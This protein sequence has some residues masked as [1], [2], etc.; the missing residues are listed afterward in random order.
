MMSRTRQPYAYSV[1]RYVHDVATGECVNVGVVVTALDGSFVAGKFR[2]TFL[3]I[4]QLFPS[5]D[6]EAF[7][8]RMGSIQR[9]FERLDEEAIS[10]V[11]ADR[12]DVAI[13]RYT[14]AVIPVDDSSLQWAASGS[15]VAIDRRE[16][17]ADLYKR[18]VT[19]YDHAGA[20]ERRKDDDVWRKFRSELEKRNVLARLQEK[21][22]AVA[23][24]AVKFEHAWKNGAWHCY[25][26]VSFDLA[27]AAAIR[28]KAHRWLGQIS[29]VQTAP[30]DFKVYFLVGK[31]GDE[32][33]REHYIKA[34]SILKKSDVA[35]IVEEDAAE[36][37]SIAVA[38]AMSRHDSRPLDL[39]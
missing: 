37:F 35:Q 23:D 24:D 32:D 34:L 22:I 39:Q 38:D 21:T 6:G 11:T 19:H 3:R 29:S 10:S 9:A 12:P 5:L 14:R 7:K 26:P 25:E 30:V 18:F 28:E 16:V 20:A 27:S 15:G 4:K 31:P 17:L 13:D 1:L 36:S 33:M 8:A 2:T